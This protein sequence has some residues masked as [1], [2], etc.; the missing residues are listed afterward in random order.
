LSTR[1]GIREAT[2]YVND[3]GWRVYMVNGKRILIRGAAWMTSDMLLRLDRRRYDVLVR[4]AKEANLNMLRSE[5]FSIR[6]TEDFFNLCD[7]YGVMVTQ[8]LFGRSIPNEELAIE[9]VKDTILRIRNH[10]SLV[11]FLG[12]DET[13][14]T[15]NLDQAYRDLIAG[16]TPERTYQPH[17]GAFAIAD[18]FKTGGTRTGSRQLWTYADPT[19]YYVDTE[20][21]AWGFAQ[22][23]GIGGVIAPIESMR[24]MMPRDALWPPWTD[25]WSFHTVI[26]GGRYFDTLREALNARYGP[27]V[28][29]EEFCMKGQALNYESARAMYEAYGRNKYSATGITQWKYDTA[30]PASPTWQ[31]VDWYLLVGGAYY[32]AKKA[33]EALHVQYSYDDNSVWVVNAYY[34]DFADLT[35][36]ARILNTDMT[37][38][39]ARRATVG[40]AADGNARAFTIELPEGLT[41]TYFLSLKLNDASG[42][43]VSSNLYWLSTAP[44]VIEAQGYTQDREFFLRY[45]SSADYTG[46][47][48]LPP[49]KLDVASEITGEDGEG[50]AR[51]RIH[52]STEHL[53]LMVHVAVTKGENG[54]EVAPTFWEDNYFSLLPGETRTVS[55]A[56]A[57]GDLDGATPVVKVEGWNVRVGK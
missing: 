39:Y 57:S 35:V 24:R 8:R 40:V 4:Y 32:G 47:A 22:S 49:V 27:P 43:E 5:G 17:S 53:A 42:K 29:I 30:W 56:F 36:T 34:R 26:Q 9:C 11:H 15:E 45:K 28:S 19:H 21:G 25:T 52:N 3:E 7:E 54:L 13:F 48:E 38:K 37:E 1:F 44:D 50:K 2:T 41:K 31:L 20:R 18:R 10:P 51:V 46:L 33:C 14:P 23:G 55:G 16:Y 6:E 12:H